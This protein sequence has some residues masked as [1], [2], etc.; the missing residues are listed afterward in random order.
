VEKLRERTWLFVAAISF[1]I[2][3]HAIYSEG[4]SKNSVLYFI[5][6]LMGLLM[7]WNRRSNRLRKKGEN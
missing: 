7:F 1:P 6:F 3:I 4:L 5:V 2:T